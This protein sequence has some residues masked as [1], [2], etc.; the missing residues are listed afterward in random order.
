MTVSYYTVTGTTLDG[1]FDTTYTIIVQMKAA[2]PPSF[3]GTITREVT[4]PAQ[5]IAFNDASVFTSLYNKGDSIDDIM[6]ISISGDGTE[7]GTFKDGAAN[8]SFGTPI[9]VTSG[10]NLTFTAK[11][12]TG[13]SSF[14]VYA[15]TTSTTQPVIGPAKLTIT[16]KAAPS[17]VPVVGGDRNKSNIAVGGTTTFTSTDF[18]SCVTSGTLTHVRITSVSPSG[19][20]T[21]RYNNSAYTLNTVIPLATTTSPNLSHL[22]FPTTNTGNVTITWQG[23]SD[24]VNFSSTSARVRFTITSSSTATDIDRIIDYYTYSDSYI[25][26]RGADFYNA[27]RDTNGRTLSYVTF[28]LP[29]SSQGRLY[30]N[31][32]TSSNTGTNVTSS[33]RYYYSSSPDISDVSFV[34][35]SN[36]NSTAYINYTAYDTNGNSYTGEVRITVDDD[37]YYNQNPGYSGNV[38]TYNTAK[39]TPAYFSAANFNSALS[40]ATGNTLS[41]I[42]FTL[43]AASS[44]TLYINYGSSSSNAGVVTSNSNYY[45][46][47]NPNISDISFVPASGYTGTVVISYSSYSTNGSA[48]GGTLYINVGVTGSNTTNEVN[49]STKKDTPIKL[50]SSDFIAAFATRTTYTYSHIVFTPPSA[51]MGRLLYNYNN[52]SGSFESVV[53]ATQRFYPNSTPYISSITFVPAANF[54]GKVAI[55]FISY[56]TNGYSYPGTLNITV[57]TPETTPAPGGKVATLKLSSSGGVPVAMKASEINTVIKDASGKD[58]DYVIFTPPSS[59]SGIMYYDYFEPDNY[60]SKVS[61]SDKFYRLSDPYIT[62][63]TFVPTPGYSGT[64]RIKYTAHTVSGETLEGD[65]TVAIRAAAGTRPPSGTTPPSSNEP[66]SWAKAEVQS[67]IDKKVVPADLQKNYTGKITRAEFTALLINTYEYARGEYTQAKTPPFKDISGNAYKVQI[68]KGYSLGIIAGH[69]DTLFGPDEFLTREQAAKIICETAAAIFDSGPIASVFAL[70]YADNSAIALWARV[71]VAYA[72]ENK[73]MIGAEANMFKPLDN[74]T[75]EEAMLLTERLIVNYDL[76]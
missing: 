65:I 63:V 20:G 12:T 4:L 31:Y 59:A 28:S 9:S 49:Y 25:T 37:Y 2:V 30:Y 8:Y 66:S 33:T 32:R 73:L 38:V 75:R 62:D 17:A 76:D 57:G 14:D 53:N 19:L 71:Y 35:N 5:T 36:Y 69:S 72:T 44:G 54:T 48:Y 64:A 41:H 34:P 23:S 46:N 29:S 74:L 60:D 50:V 27:L 55:P 39:D 7:N 58:V 6:E 56:S 42:R 67:L 21:L 3:T 45:R 43:P 18:T 47:S 52:S 11:G 51:T 1:P 22:T 70:T 10:F 15:H 40:S 61:S 16:V 68:G 26:F 24:G 13:T